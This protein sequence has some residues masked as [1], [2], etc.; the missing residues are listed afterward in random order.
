MTP[1]SLTMAVF[2]REANALEEAMNRRMTGM[3]SKLATMAAVAAL[4][5]M[6][7]MHSAFAEGKQDFTLHNETGVTINK[8]FISTHDKD[9]WEEDVLGVDQLAAGAETAI[10]FDAAEDA[11]KWDMKVEDTEGNSLEWHDLNLSEITDITLHWDP[12]TATGT[13]ETENGQ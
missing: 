5:V 11:N 10:T 7:L 8:L 4:S 12:A 9:E 6:G 3:K 1:L 13:A 2:S